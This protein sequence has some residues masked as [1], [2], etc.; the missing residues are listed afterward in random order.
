MSSISAFDDD[1]VGA[2]ACITVIS[3]GFV[4]NLTEITIELVDLHRINAV[5]ACG[6]SRKHTP[7][8]RSFS[9]SDQMKSRMDVSPFPRHCT[10]DS[11]MGRVSIHSSAV[12]LSR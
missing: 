1:E 11:P 12:S 2:F 10:L 6:L 3:N 7:S 4:A 8:I 9:S 5:F